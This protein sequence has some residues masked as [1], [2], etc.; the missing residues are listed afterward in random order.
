MK[1]VFIKM[2]HRYGKF[3]HNIEELLKLKPKFNDALN[4]AAAK[5]DHYVLTINSCNSYD[6][7]AH[8]ENL[9]LKGKTDFWIKIDDL[10]H[11]F[12]LNKVKLLPNLKNPP[13]HRNVHCRSRNPSTD[14]MDNYDRGRKLPT[15]P[16]YHQY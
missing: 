4:D 11:R 10:L 9:S 6:H 16:P 7:F 12:D 5:I 1:I 14:R 13:H 8:N 2:L 3:S 15:P